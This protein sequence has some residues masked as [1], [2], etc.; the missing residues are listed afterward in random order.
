MHEL[1]R[2]KP[3]PPI[4]LSLQ[5]TV[6]GGIQETTVGKS[7]AGGHLRSLP[8]CGSSLMPAHP[9]TAGSTDTAR[10]RGKEATL[11][12]LVPPGHLHAAYPPP[13]RLVAPALGG[14]EAARGAT[15]RDIGDPPAAAAPH[16]AGGGDRR[17]GSPPR[18]A[19]Q[20]RRATQDAG[21][22]G[23][24]LA[25]VPTLPAGCKL[26]ARPS[27]LRPGPLRGAPV[28]RPTCVAL[29]NCFL[30]PATDMVREDARAAAA[31]G[32]RRQQSGAGGPSRAARSPGRRS[33]CRRRG[34]GRGGA[35]PRGTRAR[36]ERHPD[37]RGG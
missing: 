27:R 28:T 9:G 23:L 3:H 4:P 25:G 21:G 19:R 12:N 11:H 5:T 36:A 1:S 20:A 22:A 10:S 31:A 8:Q 14:A 15:R 32:R 34:C 26:P 24:G 30:S 35:E 6:K 37:V 18:D 7:A 16:R 29:W 13:P 33:S 2:R 17:E